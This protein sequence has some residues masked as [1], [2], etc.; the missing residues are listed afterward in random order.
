MTAIFLRDLEGLYV[1]PIGLQVL[2]DQ[3]DIHHEEWT[4]GLFN[5]WANISHLLMSLHSNSS[6]FKAPFLWHAFLNEYSASKE[7]IHPKANL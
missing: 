4:I 2:V 1:H 6:M 7:T 5:T 3:R